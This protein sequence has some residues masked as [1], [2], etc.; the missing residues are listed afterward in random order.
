LSGPAEIG[1]SSAMRVITLVD[2]PVPSERPTGIGVAAFNMA[3]ALSRR[4]VD[5]HYVCRGAVE[6]TI[7]MNDHLR[8]QTIRNYSRDNVRVSLEALRK[9]APDVFHVHSTAALP[10]L[11]LGRVFGTTVAMHSHG[12]EPLHPIRLALMRKAGMILS[13]RVIAVSEATR[14]DII[15]TQHLSPKKIAVVYNGVSVEDFRPL[16]QTTHILQKYGLEGAGK[17][18]LSVGAVQQRKGQW[19]I[20]HC[21]PKILEIWP[22]LIYVNVGRAYDSLYQNQLLKE[23]ERLGVS[24]NFRLLTGVPHDDL[25]ALINSAD[26]CVHPSTREAFG[27]AVA[28]E[29]ACARPVVALDVDA[30]HEIIDDGVNGLL[31]Q[32][33]DHD[34]LTA[35]I[36]R[37]LADTE[38]ARRIGEAA[39]AK[40]VAKFTWDQA[41]A[42]LETL[43]RE[44]LS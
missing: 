16:P 38:L 41:A 9:E 39:R 1:E 4:R 15:R 22:G 35:S 5:V 2:K 44:M 11:F 37:L 13:Q 34:N 29:M 40:V 36:L 24:K 19:T 27:L 32:L 14:D 25:V 18:L 26:V 12:D 6:E 10:S 20:I 7:S 21:L 8:V 23:A 31:V 43:F 3:L 30:M 42:D 28:E 33:N 17:I